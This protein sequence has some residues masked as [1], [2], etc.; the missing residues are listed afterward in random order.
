MGDQGRTYPHLRCP[1]AALFMKENFIF[2]SDLKKGIIESEPSNGKIEWSKEFPGK[3]KWRS[4]PTAGD[5][6]FTL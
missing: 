5:G 3:Y 2:L 6:K 1:Y 4:S